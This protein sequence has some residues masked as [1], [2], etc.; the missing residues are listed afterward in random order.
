M[1][2]RT[3]YFVVPGDLETRTGGYGYDRQIIAGL[4]QRGWVVH[5]VSLAGNYPFP[6]VDARVDAV[7]AQETQV[8][9]ASFQIATLTDMEALEVPVVIDPRDLRQDTR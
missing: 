4:R 5:L 9:I 2:D 8:V 3:L 6:S 1:I 7:T